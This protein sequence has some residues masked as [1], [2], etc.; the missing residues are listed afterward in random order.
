M[1]RT[2]SLL[3]WYKVRTRY[4]QAVRPINRVKRFVWSCFAKSYEEQFDDVTDFDECTVELRWFTA[5]TFIKTQNPLLQAAGGKVG[6]VKHNFKVNIFGGI[7]KKGLTPLVIFTK[8][9]KAINFQTYLTCHNSPFK[10]KVS[11]LASNFNG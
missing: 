6:K 7:S 10:R 4:C 2:V 11:I 3:G 1:G 8:R 5:K 9:M